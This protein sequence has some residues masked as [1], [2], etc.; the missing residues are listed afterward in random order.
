[1]VNDGSEQSLS[2]LYEILMNFCKASRMKINDDKSSL[3][4]SCLEE[5]A[6]LLL[7]RIF[8]HFQ[9]TKLRMV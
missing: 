3:Y 2:T 5:S 1:M 7:Y 8:F 6:R 4:S 9:L